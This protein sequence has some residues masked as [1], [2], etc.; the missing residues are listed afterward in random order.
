MISGIYWRETKKN[1][2]IHQLWHPNRGHSHYII[3]Y[4]NK[5][6]QELEL[7]LLRNAL[8]AP[9]DISWDVYDSS[10]IS[11]E[12]IHDDWTSQT[13]VALKSMIKLFRTRRLNAE[14]PYMTSLCFIC[15]ALLSSQIT[16]LGQ[17]NCHSLKSQLRNI[18]YRWRE[19]EWEWRLLLRLLTLSGV[20][21]NIA[22]M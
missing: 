21:S 13:T 14:L 10:S 3:S 12:E 17:V 15:S 8:T 2:Y 1:R 6:L 19:I 16:Q 22:G 7:E 11:H 4:N 5:L 18:H 20:P 9:I